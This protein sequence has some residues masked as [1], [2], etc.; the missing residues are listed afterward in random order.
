MGA[1][2]AVAHAHSVAGAGPRADLVARD[3]RRLTRD[4]PCR[5]PT[6][7]RCGG[8]LEGP[9]WRTPTALARFPLGGGVAV[10]RWPTVGP[11]MAHVAP[12]VRRPGKRKGPRLSL[13][14]L[15][16]VGVATRARLGSRGGRVIRAPLPPPQ[17]RRFPWLQAS[18][19]V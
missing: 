19:A 9:P 2:A 7:G 10:V 6:G 14:R 5:D 15:G 11:A 16:R 12:R 17:L 3:D 8:R 13:V 1:M 4:P 18:E